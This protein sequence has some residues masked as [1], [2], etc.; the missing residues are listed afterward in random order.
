MNGA[1]PTGLLLDKYYVKYE[2]RVTEITVYSPLTFRPLSQA[3]CA[4]GDM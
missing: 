3:N 1:P 2:S 4:K